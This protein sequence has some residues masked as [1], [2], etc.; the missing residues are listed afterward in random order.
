M[1]EIIER[2]CDRIA[3]LPSSGAVV[4]I[5]QREWLRRMVREVLLAIREPTPAMI[6]AAI[7]THVRENGGIEHAPYLSWCAMVDELLK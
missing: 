3:V 2:A 6:E 4:G 5:S 7:M 1:N